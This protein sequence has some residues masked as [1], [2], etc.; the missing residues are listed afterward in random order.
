MPYIGFFWINFCKVL[1]KMLENDFFSIKLL[2][3]RKRSTF[4]PLW[5]IFRSS[6]PTQTGRSSLYSIYVE[7][8]PPGVNGVQWPINL[9]I[10]QFPILHGLFC[11]FLHMGVVL[12]RHLK[13]VNFVCKGLRLTEL[14]ANHPNSRFQDWKGKKYMTSSYFGKSKVMTLKSFKMVKM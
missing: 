6:R 13:I 14:I 2:K 5:R 4:D 10:K 12:P 1:N 11:T 7:V 3:S 8:P 9:L